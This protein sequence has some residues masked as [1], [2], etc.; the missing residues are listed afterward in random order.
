MWTWVRRAALAMSVWLAAACGGGSGGDNSTIFLGGS[1]QGLL[2]GNVVVL[3]DTTAGSVDVHANGAFQLPDPVASGSTYAVHVA[4]QPPGQN[5]TVSNGTGQAGADSVRDIAV[6][7]GL[8]YDVGVTIVGRA[9]TSGLVLQNN[10]G[11]DLAAP[12][13]GARHFATPLA[14][15]AAY[16]VTIKSQ[17]TGIAC[18]VRDGAG[19]VGAANV[20]VYV[21]CPS[22]VAYAPAPGRSTTL[23]LGRY[24]DETTGGLLPSVGSPYESGVRVAGVAAESGGRFL[25]AASDRSIITFSIDPLNGSLTQVR[26]TDVPVGIDTLD[27][28]H[29]TVG[30]R[31]LHA[32]SGLSTYAYHVDTDTGELALVAGS[33]FA[34]GRFGA[35]AGTLLYTSEELPGARQAIGAYRIDPVTGAISRVAGSPF[36]EYGHLTDESSLGAILLDPGGRFVYAVRVFDPTDGYDCGHSYSETYTVDSATGALSAPA[37]AGFDVR[38][39]DARGL[40]AYGVAEP[41]REGDGNI[42]ADSIDQATYR[43]TRV[44]SINL[45]HYVNLAVDPAT[46]FIYSEIG[47][48]QTDPVTGGIVGTFSY[49]GDFP[50]II[51]QAFAALAP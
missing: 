17:P 32:M 30:G 49:A 4:I 43:L 15:G 7:C 13:S 31:F 14:S 19:V 11:D 34:T 2:E 37:R 25:Y 27:G 28:I 9:T 22:R 42:Y 44:N 39:I 38:G 23:I 10:G 35:S 50:R 47:T 20:N 33:P 51:P 21:V 5:C 16:D 40:F 18:I 26:T 12:V 45:Q 36:G 6:D 29:A 24:I 48:L 46:P 1:V 3:E 41:C 8:L